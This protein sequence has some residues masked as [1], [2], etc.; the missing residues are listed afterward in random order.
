MNRAAK[1]LVVAVVLFGI[2]L[3]VAGRDQA[4]LEG[5]YRLAKRVLPDG[6]E[7]MP[8]DIVGFMTFTDTYRNFNIRW[9]ELDG[10]VVA[11]AY[12]AEYTLSSDEYCETP[13]HWMQYNL[14]ESGLKLEAP[15]AKGECSAVTVEGDSIRFPI[16]GEPVVA[17][18][19][20]DAMTATAG[21]EFVDH[22]ERVE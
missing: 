16:P 2:A 18:V 22:W 6:T 17:E 13:L 15:A 12:V 9:S 7:I 1:V 3:P 5:S 20:A 10:D 4:A 14:E 11:I 8:P 19:S 21:G